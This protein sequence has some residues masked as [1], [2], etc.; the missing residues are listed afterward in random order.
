M[1]L[2]VNQK[3]VKILKVLLLALFVGYYSSS[4]FFTHTHYSDW[5]VITHSHPYLPSGS[6]THATLE[7]QLIEHLSNLVLIVIFS[8]LVVLCLPVILNRYNTL[9]QLCILR[10]YTPSIKQRG[11]PIS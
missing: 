1:N 8:L 9:N 6:H 10:I 3:V 11:P 4:M 2:K 5:G 7:Y